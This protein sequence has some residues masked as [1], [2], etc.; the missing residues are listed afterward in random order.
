MDNN[1]YFLIYRMLSLISV[2]RRFPSKGNDMLRMW[3][4]YGKRKTFGTANAIDTTS[5]WI[6]RLAMLL[7]IAT[8]RLSHTD[9][10]YLGRLGSIASE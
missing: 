6:A 2:I 5:S 9:A 8:L 7:V 4:G 1:A 10:G 3:N